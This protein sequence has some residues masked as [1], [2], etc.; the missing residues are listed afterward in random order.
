MNL[1]GPIG[2]PN[3][4]I[5][6]SIWY[7]STP[8]STSN[9]AAWVYGKNILLTAKPVQFPTTTGV[10]LIFFPTSTKSTIT[11]GPVLLVRTTSNSGMTCAGLHQKH[12][13]SGWVKTIQ[14]WGEVWIC[15]PKK[16]SSNNSI[17][18]FCSLANQ[19]QIY[20][21][22]ICSKYAM[23]RAIFLKIN[24]NLL[25]QRDIL[26]NSLLQAQPNWH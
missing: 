11:W 8:C 20:C 10:F 24:E 23:W 12:K 17:V 16:M 6:L 19:L 22:R 2:M 1:K 5:A 4:K 13:L 18:R 15:K 14:K 9:N 25:L 21:G 7:G 26:Y 3:L